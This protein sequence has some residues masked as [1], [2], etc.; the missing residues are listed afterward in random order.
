[1]QTAR[2][3]KDNGNMISNKEKAGGGPL[4]LNNGKQA[5]GKMDRELNG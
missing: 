1:M 4:G 5:C 2:F 3:S